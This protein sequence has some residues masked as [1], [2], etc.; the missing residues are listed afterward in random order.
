M[1]V[2]KDGRGGMGEESIR[3]KTTIRIIKIK[4]IIKIIINTFTYSLPILEEDRI[5]DGSCSSS[6]SDQV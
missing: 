4:L 6:H 5:F 1:E 2:G 3:R